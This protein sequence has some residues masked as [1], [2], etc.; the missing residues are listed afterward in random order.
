[1]S[2]DNQSKQAGLPPI[3]ILEQIEWHVSGDTGHHKQGCSAAAEDTLTMQR[4]HSQGVRRPPQRKRLGERRVR[5]TEEDIVGQGL[6]QKR[7]P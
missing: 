1:M 6:V 7:S 4:L 5:A 2:P 3:L